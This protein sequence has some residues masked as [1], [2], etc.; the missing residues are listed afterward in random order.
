MASRL[1]VNSLGPH[2]PPLRCA[3]RRTAWTVAVGQHGAPRTLPRFPMAGRRSHGAHLPVPIM[4]CAAFSSLL[5]S[6]AQGSA[7]C[8]G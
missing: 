1:G 4:L 6:C 8:A 5:V 3:I 7:V 2:P